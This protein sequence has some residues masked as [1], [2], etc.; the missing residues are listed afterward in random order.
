MSSLQNGL[1]VGGEF[2]LGHEGVDDVSGGEG[3]GF[4]AAGILLET[5]LEDLILEEFAN[6]GVCL[7]VLQM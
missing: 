7:L 6:L 3:S 1:V 4:E 5:F 2:G